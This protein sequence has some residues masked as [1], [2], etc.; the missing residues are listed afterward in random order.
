MFNIY[1][2]VISADLGVLLLI[3]KEGQL[4]LSYYMINILPN[5]ILFK[6]L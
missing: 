1:I 3:Q 2:Y 4:L 5:F 6:D